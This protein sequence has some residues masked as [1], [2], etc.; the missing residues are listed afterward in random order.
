MIAHPSQGPK[1][2]AVRKLKANRFPVR[3]R[4]NLISNSAFARIF[5]R[6]WCITSDDSFRWSIVVKCL[7]QV[8][9]HF[10][11][12]FHRKANPAIFKRHT[13]ISNE[14]LMD[15]NVYLRKGCPMVTL[16]AK[17]LG[18]FQCSKRF[19]QRAKNRR[20]RQ[21]DPCAV[22]ISHSSQPQTEMTCG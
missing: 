16:V 18:R 22:P 14:V 15:L 9:F 10:L 3:E 2:P 4:M 1:V 7:A 19:D 12:F 8:L 5:Q 13:Y 6:S 11:G 21:T 20:S 17:G